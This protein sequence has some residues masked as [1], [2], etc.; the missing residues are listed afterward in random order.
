MGEEKKEIKGTYFTKE[1]RAL[2]LLDNTKLELWID[3]KLLYK[4]ISITKKKNIGA[5]D[6][7]VKLIERFVDKHENK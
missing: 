5:K 3:K 6:A 1:E 2:F 7:V 4:F